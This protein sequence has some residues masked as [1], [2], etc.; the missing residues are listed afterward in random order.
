MT[1]IETAMTM[2]INWY[3]PVAD[4]MSLEWITAVLRRVI[5]FISKLVLVLISFF[6]PKRNALTYY[7]M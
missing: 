1:V 7:Y 4:I 5:S 3:H 2:F 6:H